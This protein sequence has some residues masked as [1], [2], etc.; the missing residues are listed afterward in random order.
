MWYK[1]TP[2]FLTLLLC[3]P[4]QASSVSSTL[5]ISSEFSN[6]EMLVITGTIVDATNGTPLS[7]VYIKQQDSLN[8]AFSQS[9]GRF[10]LRLMRGFPQ[11]L[12]FSLEGYEPIE[13][14]FQHSLKNIHIQLHPL[15]IYR[16]TFA[17]AHSTPAKT[18][19]R[20]FGDQFTLFYQL[21]YSLLMDQKVNI[22]GFALNEMGL[23]T[24]LLLFYPLTMRGRFYRGRLPVE[25]ANFPFQPAFFVNTLQAKIGTGWIQ[26]LT[27]HLQLYLGGDLLFHNQ[28]PDNRSNQDQAPVPFTG[29]VLDFEQNRLSLGARATLAWKPTDEFSVFPDLSLYPVGA[30]FVRQRTS[31]TIDYLV[32]GE[33]GLKSQYEIIPGIY[34]IANYNTQFWYALGAHYFNNV[35]F[36]HFGISVD[37]W[38]LSARL[39]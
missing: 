2:F 1:L 31:S 22:Q 32:A 4:S 10:E 6:N 36:F 11:T 38:T 18:S 29:S 3:M 26:D 17:P 19:K 25:V 16:P 13:L 14:N 37:P 24:D 35:H 15:T 21:N 7:N 8:T 30:N 12:I 33:V 27:P 9:D 39:Q 5:L 28:S 20:I 34:A 23:D